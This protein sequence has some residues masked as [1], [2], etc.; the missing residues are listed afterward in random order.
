MYGCK[1]S[2]V[3]KII[4]IAIICFS[5]IS[6]SEYCYYKTIVNNGILP[7]FGGNT[8]SY[9]AILNIRFQDTVQKY[10]TPIKGFSNYIPEYNS[11]KYSQIKRELRNSGGELFLDSS[12]II[13][14][15]FEPCILYQSSFLDSIKGISTEELLSKYFI[16]NIKLNAE[17]IDKK[18]KTALL[19]ILIK[20][21]QLVYVLIGEAT[22]YSENPA[23]LGRIQ[24]SN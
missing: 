24:N 22:D 6:C 2:V 18:K 4:L 12:E 1:Y 11:G 16:N 5:F 9:Y 10:V 17:I 19:Y 14:E 8:Y 3:K 15:S 13:F 7:T 20:R 21:K 23:Y